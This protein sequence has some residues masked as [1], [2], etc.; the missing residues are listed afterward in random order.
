MSLALAD[1]NPMIIQPLIHHQSNSQL[2]IHL[3][4]NIDQWLRHHGLVVSHYGPL[5]PV[6]GQA[7]LS[8]VSSRHMRGFGEVVNSLQNHLSQHGVLEFGDL[9][10]MVQ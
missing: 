1:P 10:Y 9:Q 5:W 8:A 3:F 2:A 6:Y 7:S 4:A